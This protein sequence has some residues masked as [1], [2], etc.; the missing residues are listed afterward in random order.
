[1]STAGLVLAAVGCVGLGCEGEPATSPHPEAPLF[2]PSEPPAQG[3]LEVR[4]VRPQLDGRAFPDGLLAL[5]W[6]DG[7]DANTLALASYLKREH[8]SAT[9]FVVEEWSNDLSADPGSGKKEFETGYEYLP[10][11]GDLVGLGHRVGNHTLNH[12]LLSRARPELLDIELKENQEHIDP[13]LT[14]E[15]RIFRAPGGAWNAPASRVTDTDPYLYDLIG[16]IRWDVDRKDWESSLHC[17]SSHPAT[18]C[19]PLGPG[20]ER[21]VKPEVVADRYLASIESAGHGVVLFHDRVG[22][23][24]S[25]YAL[26]VAEQLIPALRQRGYVFVA[27][28]LEFVDPLPRLASSS[29]ESQ[30]RLTSRSLLLGD[31]DGDG[32]ADVC[33]HSPIDRRCARSVELAGTMEDRRPRTVFEANDAPDPLST[34]AARFESE[35]IELADVN[36]DG[37]RDVCAMLGFGIAC[38]I[39]LPSGECGPEAKWSLWGEQESRAAAEGGGA[40]VR[41]G[42]IDGDGKSDVCVVSLRGIDCALSKGQGF[43]TETRWARPRSE[44]GEWWTLEGLRTIAVVDVDG[45]G[46]ADLCGVAGGGLACARSTGS[47]FGR[48]EIWSTDGRF[49]SSSPRVFGDLNGDGRADVCVNTGDEIQCALSRG[50]TFAHASPWLTGARAGATDSTR[51]IHATSLALGDVNGDGRS[52]LCGYDAAGVV[53]ALAP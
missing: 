23:V 42:D 39:V 43:A 26:Q 5:T 3:T 48:R 22:D 41:F 11:L 51:L 47:S 14:N 13:Y 21:R 6:D 4:A 19:E 15:L 53:C 24:G 33:V 12:V 1:V 31:L 34:C 20:R 2:R 38:A 27:P 25:N 9:F 45:D 28:V 30:D 40:I 46:R 18:E 8:V 16:P 37:R 32:R 36:G 35:D 49:S 29:D 44:D 50:N 10:I 7:P 52:D 17:R